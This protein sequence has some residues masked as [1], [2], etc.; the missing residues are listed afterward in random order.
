MARYNV[1]PTKTTL[2]Q[3]KRDQAFALEGH[4]LLEQKRDILVAE[5]MGLADKASGVQQEV[6]RAASEAY[7]ALEN[8][9]VRMGRDRVNAAAQAVNL[10]AELTMRRREVVG[11]HL[12]AVE[13]NF[14]APQPYYS[15]LG[16]SLRVDEAAFTFQRVLQLLAQLAE[17]KISVLRLSAEVKKTARRVNALEQIYLPDYAATI[18]YINDVLEE[19]DREAFFVLKLI[20]TR[21]TAADSLTA[22]ATI[23]GERQQQ[24]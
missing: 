16:T 23:L 24:E 21:L 7:T 6:D 4:H 12:P 3:V 2:F 22:E 9:V 20:K 13:V 5:L 11:V 15:L 19:H 17:L 10:S 18:K 14:I 1:A 8:A